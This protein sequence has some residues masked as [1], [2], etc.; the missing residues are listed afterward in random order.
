MKHIPAER[1]TSRTRCYEC[2]NTLNPYA[3]RFVQSGMSI[4]AYGICAKCHDIWITRSHRWSNLNKPIHNNIGDTQTLLYGP[5][6]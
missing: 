1:T 5:H 2:G 3:V 6:E 4:S